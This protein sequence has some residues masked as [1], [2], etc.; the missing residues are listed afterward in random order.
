[1]KATVFLIGAFLGMFMI[2]SCN[3]DDDENLVPKD[4]SWYWGYFKGTINGKEFAVENEGHGEWPVRTIK[5][6]ASPPDNDT[7]T[8]RGMITGIRYS[9][10]ESLGITLYHLNKGVRYITRSTGGD[11]IY[12]GVSIHRYT[13][14]DKYEDK[15]IRYIPR[16][17]NPFRV[18]I[19]KCIYPNQFE[20]IIEATLDGVL[21]RS[22]NYKD[23][24]IVKG[25]YGTR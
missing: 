14:R 16:Q 2:S 1:M 15:Y 6:S 8:I 3:N 5:T 11:W 20:P 18:E 23:S 12:D 13:Y 4:D 10:N 17:E 25:S 21:Y 24:I 9:E 22:D 7:D 19:T